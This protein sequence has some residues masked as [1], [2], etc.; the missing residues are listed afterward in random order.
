MGGTAYKFI[1]SLSRDPISL[2]DP[3]YMTLS[4]GDN[5]LLILEESYVASEVLQL[6]FNSLDWKVTTIFM[7]WGMWLGCPG[8]AYDVLTFFLLVLPT[9]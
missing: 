8:Y 7:I 1:I 9:S 5:S 2:S 3:C 6:V 4:Y